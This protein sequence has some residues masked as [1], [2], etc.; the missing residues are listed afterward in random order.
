[1]TDRQADRYIDRKIDRKTGTYV[2]EKTQM[3]RHIDE[4]TH[5]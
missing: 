3:K 1:L 2:D 4:K 5:R